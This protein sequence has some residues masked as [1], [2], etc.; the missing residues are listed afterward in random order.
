MFVFV[1]NYELQFYVLCFQD[2][3]ALTLDGLRLRY[4]ALYRLILII[5]WYIAWYFVITPVRL[6]AM[7]VSRVWSIANQLAVRNNSCLYIT[8]RR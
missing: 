1:C 3:L 2:H 6:W 7:F 5:L 4:I 8:K